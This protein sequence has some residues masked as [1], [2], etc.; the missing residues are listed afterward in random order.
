MIEL[1][2]IGLIINKPGTYDDN[3]EQIKPP[4]Y[5]PGW[6]VNATESIPE[7][8]PYEIEVKTPVRIY[9][10]GDTIFLR[11]DSEAHFDEVIQ[12]LDPVSDPIDD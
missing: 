12:S 9:A 4:T 1:S 3:G 10:G 5:V 7:F 11:F 2:E 8:K 6:H